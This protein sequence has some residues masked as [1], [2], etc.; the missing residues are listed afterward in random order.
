MILNPSSK[1]QLKKLIVFCSNIPHCHPPFDLLE[2][3]R[4]FSN[5]N[6]VIFIDVPTQ[7]EDFNIDY[8]KKYIKFLIQ[9]KEKDFFIWEFRINFNLLSRLFFSKINEW[10]NYTLLKTFLFLQK[11][12]FSYYLI[13][14]ITSPE[15]DDV[16]SHIPYDIKIFDCKDKTYPDQFL[17]N[18]HNIISSN[19]ILT[20]TELIFNELKRIKTP[21]YKISSGYYKHFAIQKSINVK[22]P[23]SVLFFGGISHRIDYNLLIS[24]IEKL[25]EIH[26]FFIGEIYLLK[27]YIDKKLDYVCM[28]KWR[29]LLE[30]SNVHFLGNLRFENQSISKILNLF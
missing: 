21:I 19:A 22:I 12:L 30:H 8:F 25:P 27:Y 14:I 7:L 29:N 18:K 23:N 1:K 2:T 6:K 3:A 5:E 9:N 16:Y 11:S 28:K 20:N 17:K 24:V 13:L 4:E 10:V 15:N 26:F